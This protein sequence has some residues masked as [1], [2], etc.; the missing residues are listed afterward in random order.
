MN[1]NII[2]TIVLIIVCVIAAGA[3]TAFVLFYKQYLK[4]RKERDP[5]W[6][7]MKKMVEEKDRLDRINNKEVDG[8][9]Y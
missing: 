8:I 7:K 5:V 3:V 2:M 6:N 1:C 9:Y 4:D